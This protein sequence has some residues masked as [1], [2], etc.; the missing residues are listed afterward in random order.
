MKRVYAILAAILLTSSLFPQ[1]PQKMSYQAVIRNASDQLVTTQIGMR[2]SILQGATDGTEVY[3]ETQTPTPNANG[4]VTIEIGS[5][6]PGAFAA[7]DWS[8]GPYY[9]KTETATEAPLTTYT[10][11]GTSQL[12]SV[13]YAL[14]AKTFTGA[15]S[16]GESYGGGIIFW[17]DASG[18]HG[19]IAATTDQSTGIQWY[20]GT[21]IITDATLD[22]IYAGK[23][24]TS[25]IINKQGAGS[26]AAQ[27]CN[28]YAVTVNNE[29]YDD[30]YLPSKFEL[31]LLYSQK[32]VVGGFVD[33]GYWNSTEKTISISWAVNFYNG[34]QTSYYKYSECYVRA[35][36]AF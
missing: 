3:T 12:L 22:G 23:A 1:S 5:G 25:L 30:W 2:I 26:Y 34:N 20:N 14:Y 36:R 33:D 18:Q 15:H 8:A 4:L 17:L 31:S 6:D 9:I 28:D 29:Y 24:N 19:L 27:V 16:I 21:D 35:I 32:D 7:I 11:T 10:I 13:P